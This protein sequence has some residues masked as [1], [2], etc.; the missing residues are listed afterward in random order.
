M[1][2]DRTSNDAM[3]GEEGEEEEEGEEQAAKKQPS[4]ASL[5]EI[6]KYA[7]ADLFAVGR[8]LMPKFIKDREE[9]KKQRQLRMEEIEEACDYD[10]Y[11]AEQEIENR[12][13]LI[14]KG[15]VLCRQLYEAMRRGEF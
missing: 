8:E 11:L 10:E 6:H 1:A 9:T 13:N 15:P 4:K 7:D 5:G 14:S 2:A 3:D 12:S